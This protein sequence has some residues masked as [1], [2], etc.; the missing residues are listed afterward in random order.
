MIYAVVVNVTHDTN[1]FSP[2]IFCRDANAF[3]ERVSRIAPI[4]PRDI[5][6]N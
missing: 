4:P 1:D 5:F 6:G 2:V 3:V